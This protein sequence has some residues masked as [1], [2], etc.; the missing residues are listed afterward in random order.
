MTLDEGATAI[1][2]CPLDTSN[3]CLVD[4]VE[5]YTYD[6]VADKRKLLRDH[7]VETFAFDPLLM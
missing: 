1:F 2:K 3:S 7:R 5:W 4:L 6:P